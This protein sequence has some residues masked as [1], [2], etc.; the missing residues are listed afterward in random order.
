M[1]AAGGQAAYISEPLNVLHRPGVLISPTCYWY[2]YICKENEAAFLPGL[3]Q[4]IQFR[5]HLLAEIASLRSA[6]DVGRMGRD[7]SIFLRG[8]VFKKRP[9][10]KDPFAIFSTLWFAERLNCEVVITVR[11]PAA[12]VSSLKRLNWPFD[13]RDLLNQPLL[14]RDWLEP[15]RPEMEELAF[16]PQDL[17][18][19]NSLLWRM[20]YQTVARLRLSHPE[21]RLVRHED[22]SLRPIEE[23]QALFQSLGLEFTQKARQTI[24]SSSGSENPKELSKGA[25]HSIRLDSRANLENWKHR[26][27]GQEIE[28]IRQI[29]GA[30]ATD[31]Y[32][33][34]EWD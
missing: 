9:L 24:L 30:V 26:L 29:T 18:G 31:Y 10:V 15:Y 23:F 20:V 4:T 13:L 3:R 1:L 19:Q 27:S 6:K 11:H 16:N 28:R 33:D 22:L 21:F 7:G 34:L 8:A 5:Y 2:T 25:V 17:V 32:P 12:F 14:M